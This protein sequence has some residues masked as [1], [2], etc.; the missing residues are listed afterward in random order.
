MAEGKEIRKGKI[1]IPR[2]S[3]REKYLKIP[4]SPLKLT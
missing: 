3:R 4:K 2:N 1:S